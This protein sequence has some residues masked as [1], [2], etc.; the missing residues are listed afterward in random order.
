[1]IPPPLRL[2]KDWLSFFSLLAGL[3]SL[4]FFLLASFAL[5]KV[6]LYQSQHPELVYGKTLQT[7]PM[8]LIDLII[9]SVPAWLGVAA[10]LLYFIY[11]CVTF[12][13]PAP[14]LGFCT[15]SLDL[16]ARGLFAAKFGAE[17][18]KSAATPGSQALVTAPFLLIALLSVMLLIAS[19]QPR[20]NL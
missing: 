10:A 12:R 3:W 11:G 6:Y 13:G 4:A 8:M 2:N 1:M 15:A 18:F 9:A 7:P 16:L 17:I 20:R 5:L 19:L 14:F